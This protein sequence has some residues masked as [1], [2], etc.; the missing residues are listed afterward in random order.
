MINFYPFSGKNIILSPLDWGLG[1]A[2]RMVPVARYLNKKNNVV[3]VCGLCAMPFLRNEL[4]DNEIIAINDRPIRYPKKK[5]TV[6]TMLR[7]IPVIIRNALNEHRFVK[8]LIR[9]RKIDAVFSDNRY[10]L[11]FKNIDCFIFTHQIYPKLPKGF[12]LLERI[13]G[14]FHCNYLKLFTKCLVPDFED[15]FSLSS[16]LAGD[17]MPDNPKFLKIGILS[18]FLDYP[19]AN[20]PKVYDYLVLISGQENQRTEFENYLINKYKDSDSKILFVRGVP[21]NSPKLQVTNNITFVNMLTTHALAQAITSSKTVICR[22]G[23]STILDL[24]ALHASA[25]LIPTP[26]Q[27]EQEYLAGHLAKVGQS[28]FRQEKQV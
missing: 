5:I 8:R 21:D 14:F 22:S 23:Y 12:G 26:G 4:P 9:Q 19:S 2:S 3:I 20:I 25:I 27:T 11:I 16:E 15:G 24:V 28:V 13:V 1:H 10:G 18:R 6:F 7:W 17:R